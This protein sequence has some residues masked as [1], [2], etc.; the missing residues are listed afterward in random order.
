MAAAAAAAVGARGGIRRRPNLS[1]L[2][3]RCATPR[4]LAA[5]HAAMLVSGRLAD[6]AFAASRLLAAHAAL[7]PPGAVLRLLASL[8][9]APNSF[10][11]NITLRA[12]A[13]S[14][15]PA[16][17][18]RFFSLLRRGSGGG[19]GSYSPGRHTFTFLLKASA[20]LPLRASEQLHALAV[21]HG[22]E[23]D[24]Y[25]ANGLVRAYSLAGLVPLARRVFDGL[26][27]R[28][29]V[30]CTTMVSGYAQNGMHEDAMRSFEEMVGDGI[31]PHGAALASVLSSCARS[32]SRGLEMG[33]R[34][35]ELME[36]RRV[37]APVVG[38][39][40]GTALVDMY[41]KT[42]AMEEATAVF[43]RMPERQTATWNA[44]I[45]GLAHHG[46][47]EVALATFHR[48]RRDG[49]PPNGATLVGVL[50]AYGCT[51]RLDE[52][53]R[54]FA[55]MEK[56]FAVAPTIQH[57]GCMVDLLGRSGLLTEAEEMIRGMTTCDADTVIWGALLNACKNH[58]DI[59][60]AERA[61]QE[62]LKLDPG[63]HGVYVVLSNM[64]A[65]AGRW[66]D[67][68]RLRKVMKRAR[69]SKI[70]GSST[71]AGDDS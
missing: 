45:T 27:E 36:S 9:C 33:R 19:G 5:V 23:R 50:S 40:L 62:M 3:D 57:Y 1:L 12:L 34:V 25:V 61:V 10:M 46:H 31:E 69:L 68:D 8:P 18:L 14:P 64:Y 13:S 11:L 53:R 16:S 48:M 39:I 66:Q 4:A 21:R 54:V 20:R 22:L 67:V 70:P 7:S 28:S 37:T 42:G 32:G 15:D 60:V 58:G 6:D 56:D 30:V 35:H 65:E 44:L 71:V 38:A 59:D 63:N 24:A 55:S 47:G 51:G 43:D 2:A 52:A 41:A 26:P 29:A 17:A 49:V